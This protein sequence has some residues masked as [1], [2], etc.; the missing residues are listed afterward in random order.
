[1]SIIDRI[2]N[3]DSDEHS[4]WGVGSG[5]IAINR[6]RSISF[7]DDQIAIVSARVK[8]QLD[9]QIAKGVSVFPTTGFSYKAREEVQLCPRFDRLTPSAK[10]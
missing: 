2:K 5:C 3:I 9:T 4:K 6:I 8:K 10:K 1:M 7:L